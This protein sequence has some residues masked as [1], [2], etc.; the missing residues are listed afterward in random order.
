[1]INQEVKFLCK[2]KITG[3]SQFK[4]G[5]AVSQSNNQV[6]IAVLYANDYNTDDAVFDFYTVNINHCKVI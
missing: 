2:N 5:V 4:Q 6:T 1:M 3:Q